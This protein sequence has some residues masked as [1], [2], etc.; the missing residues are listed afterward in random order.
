MTSDSSST[1]SSTSSTPK[2]PK[3]RPAASEGKAPRPFAFAAYSAD[4]ADVV[5]YPGE[6]AAAVYAMRNGMRACPLLPGDD[7]RAAAARAEASR[8]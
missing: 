3:A 8:A 4:F 7:I 6:T 5:V 2:A 1:T